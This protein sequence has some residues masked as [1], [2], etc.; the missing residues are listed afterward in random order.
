MKI[1]IR[2]MLVT[3]IAI[4]LSLENSSLSAAQPSSMAG[5]PSVAY[6]LK[7][8]K[9][10]HFDDAKKAQLHL[11]TVRKL[12]CEAKMDDHGGHL[13][14]SYRLKSWTA[15]TLDTEQ[16]AHQWEGWMKKSGFE[17]MH[18][19]GEDHD[20]A[21]HDHAGHD[22]G[23]AGDSHAGHQHGLADGHFYGDGHDHGH[24]S[25]EIVSYSLPNWMT[26][27]TRDQREA[28]ELVAILK[29]LGCEVREGRHD[30]HRDVVF[31]C[32]RLMHIEFQSHRAA[33]GWEDWM[34]RTG[35]RTQH[36]H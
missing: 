12:G 25:A 22:H 9:T 11:Q 4:G 13:D 2:T 26:T 35:F 14:V 8:T 32:L 21:G 7:E 1:L 24:Q 5:L 18:A 27:H 16:T 30:D 10:I 20:H 3:Q 23:T 36:V 15:L 33:S 34:K 31:R 19:H 28:D 29:G 6:R 17:T